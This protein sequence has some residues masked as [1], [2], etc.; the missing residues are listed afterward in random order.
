MESQ[1]YPISICVLDFSGV[2]YHF[3]E[4][5]FGNYGIPIYGGYCADWNP[6][7]KLLIFGGLL[8]PLPTKCFP[9]CPTEEQVWSYVQSC[10]DSEFTSVGEFMNEVCKQHPEFFE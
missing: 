8:F 5:S 2:Y 10:I 1:E 3:V 9:E 6:E 7:S 4:K